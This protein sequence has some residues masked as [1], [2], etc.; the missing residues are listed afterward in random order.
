MT[1]GRGDP[2]QDAAGELDRLG[3]AFLHPLAR[4]GFEYWRGLLRGRRLPARADLDPT[5]IPRNL[6]QIS[7]IEI[8]G[9]PPAMRTKLLGHHIR[10]R[11]GIGPGDD[12]GA[13]RPEQGRE[14]I[15]ARIRLC[16]EQA[17]PVRGVY[18]YA[19]LYGSL[20]EV[21]AEVASCPLSDDGTRVDHVISFGADFETGLPPP[22]LV[23]WP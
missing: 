14:R 20:P 12:L 10:L 4:A 9:A 1:P 16:V 7:L 23:E 2:P 8:A 11:Q 3:R 19:P 22:G 5:A 18:K 21:W 17:R 13:V 15:L 6:S